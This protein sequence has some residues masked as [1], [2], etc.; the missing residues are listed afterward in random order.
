[1]GLELVY[2]LPKDYHVELG[3]IVFVMRYP[4]IRVWSGR[5]IVRLHLFPDTAH[6]SFS[7]PFIAVILTDHLGSFGC[8]RTDAYR[9]ENGYW[10]LTES[11][12][13][14]Q[15]KFIASCLEKDLFSKV[16]LDWCLG[17]L[18]LVVTR[19]FSYLLL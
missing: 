5:N 3:L 10:F 15:E 4:Y 9:G 16:P 18:F 1:M 11:S 14:I 19:L 2:F 6:V 17:N 12:I 8:L 13:F 7:L